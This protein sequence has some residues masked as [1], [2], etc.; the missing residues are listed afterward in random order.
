MHVQPKTS[1]PAAPRSTSKS[2]FATTLAGPEYLQDAVR[3][4][5]SLGISDGIT[6][7]ISSFFTD[8]PA[9]MRL[10]LGERAALA[11]EGLEQVKARQPEIFKANPGDEAHARAE[12]AK[13]NEA[14]VM[15]AQVKSTGALP[16]R[17]WGLNPAR[18]MVAHLLVAA[19]R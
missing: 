5:Y 18:T 4:G 14:L 7:A 13:L 15:L 1:S 16:E 6:N 10:P 19:D 3:R 12:K 11:L 8:T 17:G 9:A 2:P